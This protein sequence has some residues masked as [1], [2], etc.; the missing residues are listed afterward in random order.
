MSPTDLDVH[1]REYK[2]A[3]APALAQVFY[4]AVHTIGPRRYSPEQL[5]AWAPAVPDPAG[6]HARA[7]DGRLTLVAV[8]AD[9]RVLG[10]G[11]LEAN[12]HIDL[13][14][15]APEAAGHGVASRL[16]G[17]L[18]ERGVAAG[19]ARLYVEASELARGVF[20]RNGFTVISRQD[21]ELR[22]VAI[23]NYAMERRLS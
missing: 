13:L 11:D 22:G 3:D 9:G 14:F 23:H 5:A 16:L 19:M 21:F 7:S 12:G 6:V 2:E 4:D 15:C 10:Y 20:T 18:I 17:A 8:G 1:I